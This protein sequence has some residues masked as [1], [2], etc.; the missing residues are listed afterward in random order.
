MARHLLPRI[1]AF[2]ID[3]EGADLRAFKAGVE[4]LARGRQP[5]VIFPEGEVYHVYDRLT[6]LRLRCF[7]KKESDRV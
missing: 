1:G 5:L 2:P 7:S 4:I 6:P 3:R